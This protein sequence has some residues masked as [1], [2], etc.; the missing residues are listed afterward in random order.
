MTMFIGGGW[1]DPL[2][3]KTYGNHKSSI[4]LYPLS[5]KPSRSNKLPP[6]QR[7]KVY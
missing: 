6:F 5:N 3:R 4:K 1:K 7:E 2:F